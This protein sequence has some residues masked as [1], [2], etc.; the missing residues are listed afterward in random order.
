MKK[1]ILNIIV[2]IV[3]TNTCIGKTTIPEI[4]SFESNQSDSTNNVVLE[5]KGEETIKKLLL[6][7]SSKNILSEND[8]IS[9]YKSLAFH[10][11]I[12][13][14]DENALDYAKE[15]LTIQKRTN[16][17]TSADY[18]FLTPL[19]NA[20][21]QY[22]STIYYLKKV[23]KNSLTKKNKDYNLI[24]RTYNNIGYTYY[25]NNQ[26]DSSETYYLKVTTDDNIKN[27]HSAIYGLCVGNLGQIYFIKKDYR[28]A[29]INLKI[30]AELTKE[31]IWE[32]HNNAILRIADCYYMM[33]QYN[34]SK[35]IM[36]DFFNKEKHT[37]ESLLEAYKLIG[38]IY[39]KLN[40]N[41]KSAFFLRKYIHLKDSLIQ[42]DKPNKDII[43][44]LSKSRV[45]LIK[46]DL[47][48]A[49]NNVDL[50]DAE[51]RIA[52]N[53]VKSE[54]LKNR[55]YI[56]LLGLILFIILITFIHFKSREKKNKEIQHLEN[57][58]ISSELQH[59]KRDLNNVITNLNYKRK[60]IDE[61]Q[62]KLKTLQNKDVSELSE[63][64]T[65][66]IREFNAYKSADKSIAVLQTDIEKVNLYFFNKLSTRFPLLT[67]NEKELCGFILLN[68][69][70]KDIANI[71]NVSP[72]A[73]KKAR[74]RIRKKLPIAQDQKITTFL[75][76]I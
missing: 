11:N 29:L 64:I 40:N 17:V 48:L 41:K 58:L 5:Q 43:K 25:L 7:L 37:S 2:V 62:G 38:K 57:E 27:N 9:I 20:L 16:S 63:N 3:V 15:A 23:V 34:K 66:L 50:M 1:F 51:L 49:K 73:I 12:I 70:T 74:Q 28:Q 69:S 65:L 68:L 39:N 30:D 36:D 18:E 67:N 54:N 13:G 35:V 47:I 46:K 59:K 24:G 71:R 44:A 33:H 56:I 53:K 4:N 45:N 8:S 76:G 31:T 19:F 10:L 42:Y 22:D 21:E 75:E 52:K 60:F 6:T 61:I 72:N 55:I 26:L 32:S 14:D